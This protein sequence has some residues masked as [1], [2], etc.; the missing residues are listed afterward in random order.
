M[1]SHTY[2]HIVCNE[3]DLFIAQFVTKGLSGASFEGCYILEEMC[4]LLGSLT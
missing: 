2:A 3:A 4:W 1:Y